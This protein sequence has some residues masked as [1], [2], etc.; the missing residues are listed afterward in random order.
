MSHQR[1]IAERLLQIMREKQL[2]QSE[3]AARTKLSPITVAKMLNPDS[4]SPKLTTLIKFLGA[5]PEVRFSWLLQGKGVP[6]VSS[7]DEVPLVHPA[8][9]VLQEL[10]AVEM[11]YQGLTARRQADLLPVVYQ[12]GKRMAEE[13]KR[14][15]AQDE[16]IKAALEKLLSASQ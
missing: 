1:T 11:Q 13:N 5:F 7:T 15:R 12:L 2:N 10:A 4:P 16:H 3:I 9:T 6:Y 8:M 14:I